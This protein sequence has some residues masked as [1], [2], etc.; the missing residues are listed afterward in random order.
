MELK[1]ELTVVL[2]V[3]HLGRPQKGR[4]MTKRHITL[5]LAA[6]IAMGTS[7]TS[8]QNGTPSSSSPTT[9]TTPS[10]QGSPNSATTG[11]GQM[12]SPSGNGSVGAAPPMTPSTNG[13]PNG[14]D[15][16][17]NTNTPNGTPNPSR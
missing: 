1:Q 11:A 4:M 3:A 6:A 7:A 12:S 10:T 17:T 9:N 5:A 15:Q 8:A 2:Q 14:G 13:S 16:R